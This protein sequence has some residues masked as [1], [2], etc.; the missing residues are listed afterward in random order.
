MDFIWRFSPANPF[1]QHQLCVQAVS[2]FLLQCSKKLFPFMSEL[3][4]LLLAGLDQ[5]QADQPNSLVEGLPV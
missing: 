3:L 4:D 2:N 5:P 1:L